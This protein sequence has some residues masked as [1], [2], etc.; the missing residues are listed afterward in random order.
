MA[1]QYWV[2]R[3]TF[4]TK[5]GYRIIALLLLMAISGCT[6]WASAAIHSLSQDFG[7]LPVCFIENHGQANNNVKYT[8]QGP[9]GTASFG[10]KGIRF[11]LNNRRT[12]LRVTLVN[13]GP[14]CRIEGCGKL[15]GHVSYIMGNNPS[16]WHTG[17][18]VYKGVTYR[19][20]WPGID[21]AYR[22]EGRQIKYDIYAAPHADLSRIAFHYQGAERLW[23]NASGALSIQTA[24]STFTES[25][26]GIYQQKG[27]RKIWRKGCYVMLDEYTIG[28]RVKGYDPSLPLVIDPSSDLVWSTLLGGSGDDYFRCITVDAAGHVYVTGMTTSQNIPVIPNA[29]DTTYANKYDVYVAKLNPSGTALEYAT[30]LGGDN[31]DFTA[32]FAVDSTGCAYVAGYTSSMNFPVTEGAANTIRRGSC[33]AYVAKLNPTG[34]ALVYSTLIG[35][36]DEDYGGG[37]AIDTAGCVYM[38]GHTSSLDFGTSEGAPDSTLSPGSAD[39]FVVKLN[40]TGSSILYSTFLGGSSSES[41]ETIA[42][43]ATGCAYAAGKTKS[44]DFPTT[45]EAY[46]KTLA[47]VEN[48]FVVK[49]NQTCTQFVYSTYLGGNQYECPESVIPDS[50]GNAY[51]AGRTHSPDF[52]VTPGA[53]DSAFNGGYDGF[54]IKINPEGSGLVFSTL[55]GGSGDDYI[56]ALAIDQSGCLYVTGETGSSDFPTTPGSL[57]RVLSGSDDAFV[58]K[59]SPNGASL[60]YS[61]FIGGTDLDSGM[62]IALDG[63]GGLYIAGGT[64]STDFPTT[65]GALS[66]TFKGMWD[67]FVAKLRTADQTSPSEA[68]NGT[69]FSKAGCAVTAVFGDFFYIESDNRAWGIRVNKF[70]HGLTAG[71]RADVAG[72]ISVNSDGERCIDAYTAAAD[73]NGSIAPLAMNNRAIIGTGL[74]SIGLLVKTWGRVADPLGEGFFNLSDGSGDAIKCV[75]TAPTG[76]PNPG[77]YLALTG[78]VSCEKDGDGPVRSIIKAQSWD[79]VEPVAN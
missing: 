27:N 75:V 13:P 10:D 49:L 73:G 12:P 5:S 65:L 24:G 43:D 36:S 60:M 74:S 9:Q 67:G 47:G 21:I 53:Y 4:P 18:P 25:I 52:P 33:D 57:Q 39:A 42:V 41:G 69:L 45:P 8:V 29:Y 50:G 55:L 19:A 51:V 23:I 78:V 6:V 31:S 35:G 32:G 44:I 64:S 30:F 46:R 38:T 1:R 58:S 71:V 11:D 3:H 72:I 56:H 37:M 34:T 26:P 16:Q 77:S 63:N 15:G 76:L 14:N 20:A 70:G 2:R 17:I 48:A 66:G 22:G 68:G 54:A 62:G 28:F 7:K 59:L 79:E 61:S 40:A